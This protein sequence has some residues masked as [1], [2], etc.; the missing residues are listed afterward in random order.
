MSKRNADRRQRLPARQLRLDLFARRTRRLRV[1][2]PLHGL[3][4]H[5]L[6]ARG[7]QPARGVQEDPGENRND[8][9]CKFDRC[10]GRHLRCWNISG[11]RRDPDQE[12]ERLVDDGRHTP[13]RQVGWVSAFGEKIDLPLSGR[14]RLALPAYR[15]TSTSSTEQTVTILVQ[16]HTRENPR[17]ATGKYVAVDDRLQKETNKCCRSHP[18]RCVLLH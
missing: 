10:A 9:R 16:K 14:G 4:P 13:A 1:L 6:S 15:T 8:A 17:R 3:Y 7:R 12:F 2:R 18:E 5:F 11:R